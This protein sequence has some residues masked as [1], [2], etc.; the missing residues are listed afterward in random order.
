MNSGDTVDCYYELG[1]GLMAELERK[2]LD[3][4][5]SRVLDLTVE[6]VAEVEDNI[7]RQRPAVDKL[8]IAV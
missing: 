6:I 3:T 7:R 8:E 1:K 5:F 2:L 4:Y